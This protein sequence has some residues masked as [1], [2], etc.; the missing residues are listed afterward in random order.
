MWQQLHA[1]ITVIKNVTVIDGTGNLPRENMDLFIKGSNIAAITPTRKIYPEN[2]LIIDLTGKTVMP[3]L[4]NTHGHIGLLKGTKTSALNY[5]K[6]NIVSQLEKYEKFGVGTMMS[7]GTDREIIFGLRDSSKAGKLSGAY[8][9]TAGY[10]FTTKGGGPTTEGGKD[11]FFRPTSPE[12]ARINVKTLARLKPDMIKIWVDNFGSD[13]EKIKPEVYQAIINEAHLHHIRVASHLYYLED[14]K[15]LVKAGV[16]VFAHSVR[17]TEIDADLIASMKNKGTIYIPTLSL[18]KYAY[19]Y[20]E[21]PTWIND[22]FFRVSLEPGVLAMINNEEY[23]Q[24]TLN[25]PSYQRNVKAFQNAMKNVKKLFDAGILIALG[26]DSGAQPIRT[27]GFSEHLELELLTDAGLTPLQAITVG[28]QNGAKVLGINKDRGTLE[29]GKKADF[30]ILQANP[31][32]NIKAT[33]L[34]EEVWKNGK[35][36]N[37]GP[38]K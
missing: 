17:D 16:D 20:A 22:D 23:R 24:K 33:R 34:I 6:E 25:S 8:L 4:I 10:G 21:T 31:A 1:Q 3:M 7:L 38:L 35:L 29:V 11:L 28:T 36:L 9:F 14:A 2:H 27:Q 13:V 37:K 19:A 12:E 5:T 32:D 18:D 26:T 30:I 15:A